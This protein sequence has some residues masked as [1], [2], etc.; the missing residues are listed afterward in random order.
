[1]MVL[2]RG[3]IF[4]LV[5]ISLP[6]TQTNTYNSDTIITLQNMLTVQIFHQNKKNIKK[7]LKAAILAIVTTGVY[8]L[9]PH[10]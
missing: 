1:M 8:C 5:L 7:N 9:H 3:L 10:A 4:Q 2:G 6:C